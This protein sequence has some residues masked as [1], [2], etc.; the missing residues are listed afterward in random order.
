MSADVSFAWQPLSRIPS[1]AFNRRNKLSSCRGRRNRRLALSPKECTKWVP[2]SSV[3]I[4]VEAARCCSMVSKGM[5]LGL[6]ESVVVRVL[7]VVDEG[8]ICS[9]SLSMRPPLW[10]ESEKIVKIA[11][12]GM[13]FTSCLK[14]TSTQD[15]VHI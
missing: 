15:T 6:P 2:T 12:R 1:S 7:V 8:P 10:Q 5:V 11:P 4:L 3:S 9:F 13:R 14:S